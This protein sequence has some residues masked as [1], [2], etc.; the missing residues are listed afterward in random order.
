MCI[1]IYICIYNWFTFVSPLR[2]DAQLKL[3]KRSRGLPKHQWPIETLGNS[4]TFKC[5]YM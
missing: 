1:Y 5:V 3:F 4:A 2:Q